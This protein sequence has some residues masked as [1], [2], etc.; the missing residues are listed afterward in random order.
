MSSPRTAAPLRRRATSRTA[1]PRSGRL[2][3]ECLLALILIASGAPLLLGT[4]ELSQQLVDDVRQ[5]ELVLDNLWRGSALVLRSPCDAVQSDAIWRPSMR[6]ESRLQ[7]RDGS[8]RR[9]V[10]SD[11]W[12]RAG[13]GRHDMRTAHASTGARCE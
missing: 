1:R 5:D 7:L 13:V 8:V 9:A 12:S 10:I 6:H 11:V 2:L 3:L 4:Q